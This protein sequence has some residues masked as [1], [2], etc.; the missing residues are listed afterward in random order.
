MDMLFRRASGWSLALGRPGVTLDLAESFDF[1]C[2]PRELF[3]VPIQ[4]AGM[5]IL[6]CA[7]RLERD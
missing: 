2:G 7:G 5:A 1:F 4:M 3:G 6:I